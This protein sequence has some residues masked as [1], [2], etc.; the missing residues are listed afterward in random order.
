MVPH[1][2]RHAQLEDAD[3][4]GAIQVHA[5]QAAYRGVMP[6]AYLDELD[7]DDRAAYWHHQVLALLPAQRLEVIVDDGVVVGF[8]AAG[9]EHDGQAAGV[10]ELYAINVDPQVWGRGL[11][12][13][14]LR[15]V[16][17]ELAGLGY[18][19][20]VL[21]VVPQNDRARRFYESEQWRDDHVHREDEVF[22][23]VVPE[24]RYRRTFPSAGARP[25]RQDP[26]W[27]AVGGHRIC[28][29]PATW[30]P[31]AATAC[32]DRRGWLPSSATPAL[33]GTRTVRFAERSVARFGKQTP[34]V[35]PIVPRS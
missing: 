8:A 23:V 12:R 11:G 35:S 10:G 1:S 7:A 6:D 24:M 2:I 18:R 33:E 3:S 30:F 13:A 22:G 21:W 31:V 9:P 19:E 5:W 16:T 28:P 26:L 20:A 17:A 34:R 4:I 15:S 27:T 32:G 25:V 29:A 14:L